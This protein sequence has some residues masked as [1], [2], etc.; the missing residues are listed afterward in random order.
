MSIN[1][2]VAELD[3]EIAGLT[4]EIARLT[5]IRDSLASTDDFGDGGERV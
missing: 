2:A 5:Q 1:G 3:K 4:K